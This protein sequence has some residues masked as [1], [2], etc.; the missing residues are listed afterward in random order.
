MKYSSWTS[1]YDDA[2]CLWAASPPGSFFKGKTLSCS[3][4][5]NLFCLNVCRWKYLRK[6]KEQ[7][8]FQTSREFVF[9]KEMHLMSHQST[10]NVSFDNIF[11]SWRRQTV[12]EAE[13]RFQVYDD[14]DD[15]DFLPH[16]WSESS[17]RNGDAE[18]RE[19]RLQVWTADR[20]WIS[21]GSRV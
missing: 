12:S 6:I 16:Q 20:M 1:S 15:D 13:D 5:N 21:A 7:Q 9:L 17:I 4:I 8:C 11:C 14:D 2:A 19:D 3:E 10:F 18:S